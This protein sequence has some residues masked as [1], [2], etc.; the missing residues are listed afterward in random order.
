MLFHEN[1]D[2]NDGFF[3]LPFAWRKV[4][5]LWVDRTFGK[6]NADSCVVAL[7]SLIGHNDKM[8][9]CGQQYSVALLNISIESLNN[10]TIN[11]NM[12]QSMLNRDIIKGC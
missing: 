9:V 5:S 6:W 3:L 4:K 2:L 1:D 7:N 11:D 10:W 12:Y 8:V